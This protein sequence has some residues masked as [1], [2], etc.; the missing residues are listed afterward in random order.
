MVPEIRVWNPQPRKKKTLSR[1]QV[2]KRQAKAV[3]FLRDVADDP[4]LAGE[5]EDLSVN[6]YA[7][8]KGFE[9][10]E[11]PSRKRRDNMK[12]EDIQEAVK[13]GVTEALKGAKDLLRR[14]NP[15]GQQQQTGPTS[16]VDPMSDR[17]KILGRVDDAA[18]ALADG[19]EDEALDILNGVLD[20]F[21]N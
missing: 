15:N 4:E 1:D 20:D 7:D 18:A 6:E 12:K 19:D 14:S 3:R 10:T 2:E 11:N 16:V 9:L 5:I 17:T 13:N 8:R 21:D